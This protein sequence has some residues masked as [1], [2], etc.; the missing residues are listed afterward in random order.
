M[1]QLVHQNQP[2]V[3]PLGDECQLTFLGVDVKNEGIQQTE[4]VAHQEKAA[5]PGQFLQARGVNLHL[6]Q[7]QD[8]LFIEIQNPPGCFAVLL[9][10]LLHG[11]RKAP[12]HQEEKGKQQQSQ[13]KAA[14]Q[15]GQL[16][17]KSQGSKAAQPKTDAQC[18]QRGQ[19]QNTTHQHSAYLPGAGSP[20]WRSRNASF[21]IA[22]PL[23]KCNYL[24]SKIQRNRETGFNGQFS[25]GVPRQDCGNFKFFPKHTSCNWNRTWYTLL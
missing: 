23:L 10:R 3:L 19:N 2:V 6:E 12:Q 18:A 4:M 14:K 21:I 9:H 5:F 15:Q 13:P 8:Q 25:H 16:P 22:V 17:Q 1:H 20:V 7:G 24:P 11:N